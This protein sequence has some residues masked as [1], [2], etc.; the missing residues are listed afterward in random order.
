VYAKGKIND[1]PGNGGGLWG[2]FLKPDHPFYD[3][4]SEC[5]IMNLPPD[6]EG[7]RHYH[8]SVTE[9]VLVLEGFIKVSV[10]GEEIILHADDYI[11]YLP[12]TVTQTLGVSNTGAKILVFKTPSFP[13]DKIVVAED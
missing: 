7:P 13:E 3:Q 11:R 12:G 4:R 8:S 6:H 5:V 2:A 10:D 1:P 9:Y